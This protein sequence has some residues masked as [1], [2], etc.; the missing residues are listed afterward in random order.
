M[1]PKHLII[2]F[3][4][5]LTFGCGTDFK[6]PYSDTPTSGIVNIGADETLTPLATTQKETFMG[7][8]QYAQINLKLASEAESFRLLLA[9]SV[10]AIIAAREL[11]ENEKAV[12]ESKK[13]IPQTSKFA[14][15]AIALIVSPNNSDSILTI[16]QLKEI[17]SGKITNWKQ[18]NP[19]STKGDITV[20]FDNNGSSTSRYLKD[21]LNSGKEFP[22]NC[23]AAKS[24]PDVI[25][26]VSKNENAIGVIGVNWISDKDDPKMLSFNKKIKVVWLAKHADAIYSD[27]Y[28]GPYQAYMYT[29]E[30]PLTRSI[31]II[32]REGR[33]GLGTGFA[34][35]VAGDQ[36]QRIVRLTGLLPSS[37]Y[38]RDI[39]LK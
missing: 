7:L 3:L 18:L 35:F 15:D 6:Q 30:Y 33:P 36:G 21:S 34:S 10:K 12:F 39:Q 13:L 26:Y 4:S 11:N 8:Y 29:G 2:F 23:F 9:D 19:K 17:L 32:N 27:D 31:Y 24:N 20:V 5:I 37:P 28:F 16:P 25:E 1:C 14:I 38:T 22:A